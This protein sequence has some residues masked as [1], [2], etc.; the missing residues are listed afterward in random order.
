MSSLPEDPVGAVPCRVSINMAVWAQ[1]KDRLGRLRDAC[2][3]VTFDD[4]PSPVNPR[5]VEH[6]S[7]DAWGCLWHFPGMGLD[8]QAIEH[9][10]D[11]WDKM[12]A[13]RP[14]ST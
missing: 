13:W 6:T 5:A 11:D 14:P 12:D 7:R 8:G 2:P 4:E 3:H 9:P 10:L 1:H